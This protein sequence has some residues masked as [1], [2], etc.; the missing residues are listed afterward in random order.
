MALTTYAGLKAAIKSWLQADELTDSQLDDIVDL[1]EARLNREL[2]LIVM[3]TRESLDTDKQYNPLPIGYLEMRNLQLNT[4]PIKRLEYMTPEKLDVLFDRST[5]Q[6]P[7]AYTLVGGQIQFSHA[8][9]QI[10]TLEMAFY[11]KLDAI[12][13]STTNA[14]FANSPD[15]YLYACLLEATAFLYEDQR[16][17]LWLSAYQA[18]VENLNEQDRMGR[19]SG[20]ALRMTFDKASPP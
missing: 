6:Q 7:S 14:V 9:T 11:K 4:S 10:F 3:E 18:A 19:Y 15:V 8:P 12:D 13:D 17:N 1:A 20:S 16:V 2:R 5:N